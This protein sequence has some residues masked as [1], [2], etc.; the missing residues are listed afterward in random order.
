MKT[1]D[2]WEKY[3]TGLNFFRREKYLQECAKAER[4][5]ANDHWHGMEDLDLPKPVLPLS[6]RII[7][8]KVS[9]VMAEDITMNYSV[10]GYAKAPEQ[11]QEQQGQ[12]PQ[13]EQPQVSPKADLYDEAT[14][15]FNGYSETTWEEIKEKSL[16]Q[17]MLLN[18][19]LTG[20]GV[21]HYIFDTKAKY[22]NDDGKMAQAIGKIRGEVIDGTNLFLGNPNDRRINASGRPI[23]PYIIISYRKLVEEVKQIAEDNGLSKS[24]IN[25]ITSDSDTTDQAFDKSKSELDDQNMMTVLRKYFIK[26]DTIWYEESSRGVVY[27]PETDT[28]YSIYPIATMNW[29]IRKKFAYGMG[30]MKGQIPNQI[31]INQLLAQA[32]LSAQ[33]TGTPKY[34]YDRNRMSA[35]SNRVGQAVGVDGDITN[36]AKYL[37]TGRV[38]PDMYQL[39][40][41]IITITK[42]LAGASENA[43]GDAKA[44]NTSALMWAQKQ[45]AIPLEG[46]KM[47]FYQ[48]EEDTGLIWADIWKTKFNT[49]RAVKIKNKDGVAE[50]KNFNGSN[51]KDI[52]MNLKIDVGA[53]SQWSQ[54]TNLN[55][56][57]SWLDKDRIT[58]IE[59]LER[60]PQGS[61]VKKQQLIDTKKQQA[62]A[63]PQPTDKP[64]ISIAYADMPVAGQIQALAL[65]GIMVKPADMVQMQKQQLQDETDQ[66]NQAS[67]QMQQAHA[68]L[69]YGQMKQFMDSLSPEVQT[70]L[71]AMPD[72]QMEAA[73]MQLMQVEKQGGF[74]PQ[75]N[76]IGGKVNE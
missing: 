5:Y 70:K 41:R 71:K 10:E 24:D 38:S 13:Q 61:V 40:D 62:E 36:A 66:L 58:F 51:Y 47:R 74:N 44:D 45:S 2:S 53:S 65:A 30:E 64:N 18:A 19:A 68:Q 60:L 28:G 4:F 12:T 20:I 34:I 6:K 23:Q 17:E 75:N 22:G 76:N 32:I 46:V 35:P 16:N 15:M 59:Y 54:I 63:Q 8:F 11:P 50:V 55:M 1:T 42:D 21:K 33:R 56:L 48:C 3:Q 43:L 39:I 25:L 29:D 37:D 57:N 52:N 49:T 26:N 27:C 9:S 67:Q 69:T 31:A 72:A 7:D 73:V 14:T